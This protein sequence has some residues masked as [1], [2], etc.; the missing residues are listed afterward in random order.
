[1]TKA[2][3]EAITCLPKVTSRQN[4]RK[5]GLS[6]TDISNIDRRFNEIQ[7]KIFS[8]FKQI[9]VLLLRMVVIW[10]NYK[11]FIVLLWRNSVDDDG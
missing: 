8:S 4:G 3:A 2:G 6:G 5:K 10:D 9:G 7:L 11:N 1:M